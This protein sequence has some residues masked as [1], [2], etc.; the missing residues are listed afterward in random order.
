MVRSPHVSKVTSLVSKT[1]LDL[2]RFTLEGEATTASLA[3]KSRMHPSVVR[4]HMD[5]LMAGGLVEKRFRKRGRGRPEAIYVPTPDGREIFY[6]RYDVLLESVIRVLTKRTRVR[7]AESTFRGAARV[8]ASNLGAPGNLDS[9]VPIFQEIG[10]QPEIRREN[11]DRL[12]IS[13]NCP[14]LKVA[15][16]FP[17]LVCDTFHNTLVGEMIGARG[18]RLRQA[19]SRGATEC[20]H[21]LGVKR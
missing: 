19:I 20:I 16:K 11:G 3:S 8:L 10:F 17:G 5:R 12:L 13:R 2:L 14:V 18:V 1:K 15:E 9:V 21:L 6:A 4:R 7:N